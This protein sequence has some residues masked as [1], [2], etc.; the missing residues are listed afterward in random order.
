MLQLR[1]R[2]APSCNPPVA[3]NSSH[4]TARHGT[5]SAAQGDGCQSLALEQRAPSFVPGQSSSL[6]GCLCLRLRLRASASVM[7]ARL[8]NK[9][10]EQLARGS[11]CYARDWISGRKLPRD[12]SQL[13]GRGPRPET[14]LLGA[15][16]K[17]SSLW[18]ACG[19]S[20]PGSLRGELRLPAT[21]APCHASDSTNSHIICALVCWW[22]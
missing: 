10:A 9:V 20:K 3:V 13:L 4:N 1:E 22:C 14:G 21:T 19:S 12:G 16:G 2:V 6:S 11:H 7:L 17:G 5:R 18:V 15:S 8:T